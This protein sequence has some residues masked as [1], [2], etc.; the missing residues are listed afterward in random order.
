MSQEI[1]EAD[2][3]ACE[4]CGLVEEGGRHDVVKH[5]GDPVADAERWAWLKRLREE[6]N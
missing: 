6:S 1:K 5:G 3:D 4:I 2:F